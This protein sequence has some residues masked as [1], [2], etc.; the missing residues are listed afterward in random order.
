MIRFRTK[1]WYMLCGANIIMAVICA[2]AHA[3]YLLMFSVFMSMT[4]WYVA[5]SLLA[6]DLARIYGTKE[7]HNEEI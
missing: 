5:S 1:Y 2:A 6:T 4:S 3:L 7:H